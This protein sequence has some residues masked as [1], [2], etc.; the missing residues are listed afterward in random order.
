M[1]RLFGFIGLASIAALLAVA[2]PAA[3]KDFSGKRIDLIVPYEEGSGSTIHARLFL[4]SL[5][6]ALPGHP[7]IL[8]RNIPGAGSVKGINEFFKVAKPDGLTVASLGT[9]TF[10]QYL[11]RDP[12]V[13][14][15]LP[16]FKAFLTSPFGLLVYGRK[17]F[18]MTGDPVADVKLLRERQ[19]VYGGANAT[20]SDLPALFSIGLLDIHPRTV[21]GLSNAEGRAAFERGEINLNYDNMASWNTVVKPLVDDGTA[22]P[23]FTFGFE[24]DGKVIRDPMLPSVPT[25]LEVY[26]KVNGKPLAGI[27][28]EVWKTMFSVRV[29]GSKMF[30][31]PPGTPQDIVD[32]YTKAIEEALKTPELNNKNAELVLGTYPQSTGAA[33]QA[34]L[35]NG[36]AMNDQQLAHLKKWLKDTY[37][38]E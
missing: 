22:V 6:R 31:L 26:E 17:D 9:G 12:A 7:I 37:H 35:D 28:Y 4:Q 16:K 36:V 15:P 3:A 23:L 18:G 11:L 24:K 27:D 38:V 14:Y 13:T 29:M 2:P 8:V 1:R 19:P 20:S 10:Y 25:F 21:F 32:T 33:S 34:I 5:Q 30:A